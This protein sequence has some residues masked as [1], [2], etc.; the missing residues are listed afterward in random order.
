MRCFSVQM[1]AFDFNLKFGQSI[2]LQSS[3]LLN[4]LDYVHQFRKLIYELVK[5]QSTHTSLF[6][7]I[8]I[9]IT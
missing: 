7:E 2:F 9:Q 4:P 6:R 8:Y 1:T 5:S 3:P